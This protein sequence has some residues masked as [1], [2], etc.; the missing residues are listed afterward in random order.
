MDGRD[1]VIVSALRTPFDRFGGPMRYLHSIELGAEV[2]KRILK[3]VDLPGSAVDMVYYGTC[4]PAETALECNIPGRQALL[5]AG[6]PPETLS[7]TI[8]RACCSSL[9]GII[10]GYQGIRAGFYD[11]VLVVGSENMMNAPLLARKARWGSRLGHMILEDPLFELGY[12]GEFNPVSVDAGEVALEY[13]V[14]R[15]DQDAWA[16]RS[17]MRYQEAFRQ[18]KFK[19]EIVPLEIP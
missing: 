10:F 12:K 19:D 7:V 18:G 4:M 1:V 11:V 13:G 5:K 15:E 17:Q 3:R 2:I 6:L 8:D 16:Y 14:T 9:T